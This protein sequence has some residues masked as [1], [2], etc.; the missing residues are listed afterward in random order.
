MSKLGTSLASVALVV[1]LLA[2]V[3]VLQNKGQVTGPQGAQG[4]QGL[5]GPTGQQGQRGADGSSQNLSSLDNL[6]SA[7][8]GLLA[9]LN[10]QPTQPKKLAGISGT[11]ITSPTFSVGGVVEHSFSSSFAK[12]TSTLCAIE[13]PHAT[14]TPVV[15]SANIT[16]G[17]STALYLV[18]Q[19]ANLPYASAL[20]NATGTIVSQVLLP[21]NRTGSFLFKA[22][23]T[24]AGNNFE[25]ALSDGAD[26]FSGRTAT[27]SGN[28]KG[29]RY[30]LFTLRNA[31]GGT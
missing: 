5:Q 11:E 31:G 9:S 21:A 16:T 27:S 17:T 18:A 19:T 4:E 28:T 14:S 7:L 15:L 6:L 25:L 30:L 8:Q 23:S 20:A 2:G 10:N 1:A 22:T 24:N 12:S 26:V 13:L 29:S 3:A